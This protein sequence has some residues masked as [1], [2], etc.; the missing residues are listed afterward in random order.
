MRLSRLRYYARAHGDQESLQ[1]TN[2]FLTFLLHMQVA[3]GRFHNLL[4]F[5]RRYRDDVGSEDCIGRA[6]WA[7]GYTLNSGAPEDLRSTA[8]EVFDRGLLAAHGFTSPRA[9]AFTIL[10]LCCY[11]EAFPD[12]GNVQVNIVSLARAH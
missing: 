11:Q 6:L 7:S 5:D 8:K 1:L 4:G 3:D 12:D 2:T 9:V 10:G